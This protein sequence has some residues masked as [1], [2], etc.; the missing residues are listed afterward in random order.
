VLGKIASRVGIRQGDTDGR[1]PDPPIVR[2][3]PLLGCLLEV[4]HDPLPFI[5]KLHHLYGDVVHVKLGPKSVYLVTH[6]DDV[7]HVL[8]ENNRN[9]KKGAHY[10][11]LKPMFG[12]GLMLSEGDFWLRQRRLIQPAFL[13]KRLSGFATTMTDITEQML[14]RWDRV[15][16]RGGSFDV[17]RELVSLTLS[18]VCTTMFGTDISKEATGIGEAHAY[19]LAHAEQKV[20]SLLAVPDRIPSPG[21][22]KYRRS[23]ELLHSVIDR[24]IKERRASGEDRGDLLSTLAFLRY[25]G[26][27]ELMDHAQLKD[28]IIT[29]FLNGHETVSGALGW[30]FYLLS[31]NPLAAQKLHAEV[32]RV[33]GGRTPTVD[34]IP[35]LKYTTMVIEE[36]MR[37]YPPAWMLERDTLEPDELGGYHIPANSTIFLCQWMT[38]RHED[39]WENPEGFEPERFSRENSAARHRFA[40]FPFGGGP[41]L[42]VGVNF[43]MMEMALVLAMVAQ[44]FQL[45]LVPG[46][47]VGYEP[48][49]TLR[50]KQGIPM[51]P[52]RRQPAP[53]AVRET[54]EVA[55]QATE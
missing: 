30:A 38:H 15:T 8:Q 4:Q 51:T 1:A 2:G 25:E 55:A 33:L 50:P 16:E 10:E 39:F 26:T 47:P 42:C 11:V 41:R 13:R 45:D 44:R 22:L 49:I 19:C 7:Q 29:I 54:E 14:E 32:D 35:K 17:S 3:L 20:V 46:Y 36:S 12:N 53:A 31:K 18:I 9:Y 34:D 48:V 24:F 27:N 52:R 28:E 23:V 5:A 21:N 43:A 37:L 6:P 40:Y